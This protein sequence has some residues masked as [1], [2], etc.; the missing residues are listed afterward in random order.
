MKGLTRRQFVIGAPA[1]AAALLPSL[2]LLGGC[3][4]KRMGTFEESGRAA[5]EWLGRMRFAANPHEA[6]RFRESLA[7]ELDNDICRILKEAGEGTYDSRNVAKDGFAFEFASGR[8]AIFGKINRQGKVGRYEVFL[9]E[10]A[11]V[12]RLGRLKAGGMTIPGKKRIYLLM[13]VIRGSALVTREKALALQESSVGKATYEKMRE[14]LLSER[15]DMNALMLLTARIAAETG[16][17]T[18]YLQSHL[19]S[20][21]LLPLQ[22]DIAGDAGRAMVR[23]AA[24]AVLLHEIT[25]GELEGLVSPRGGEGL[26]MLAELAHGPRPRFKLPSIMQGSTGATGDVH[27][28]SA[29]LALMELANEGCNFSDVAMGA[30][31]PEIRSATSMALDRLCLESFN[32]PFLRMVDASLLREARQFADSVGY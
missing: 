3:G 15:M 24:Y 7:F 13:D 9:L 26:S 11:G 6:D 17:N 12:T 5:V 14:L 18:D 23:D 30:G 25:H 20:I 32:K 2:A 16:S 21:R 10:G 19:V 31:E 29:R 8:G 22:K 4:K 27:A 28:D 1:I